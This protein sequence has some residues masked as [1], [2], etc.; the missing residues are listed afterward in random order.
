M[1]WTKIARS[2]YDRRAH[3]Y[4]SDCRRRAM[5]FDSAVSGSQEQGPTPSVN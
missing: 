1:P 5:V 3:R 4:A 2:R